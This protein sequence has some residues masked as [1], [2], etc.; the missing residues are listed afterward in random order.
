VV[1]WLLLPLAVVLVVIVALV[2]VPPAVAGPTIDCGDFDEAT[3]DELL[4]G[5]IAEAKEKLGMASLVLP[6]TSVSLSGTEDCLR[7]TVWLLFG[8]GLAAGPLC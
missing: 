3:C 1:R 2:W 8:I 5:V 4:R 6:M 7:Y